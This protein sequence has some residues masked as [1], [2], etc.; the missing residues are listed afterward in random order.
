MRPVAFLSMLLLAGLSSA[1]VKNGAGEPNTIIR[2]S[3]REVLLE[4]SVRDARGRMVTKLDPSQV[5]VYE[6]GVRQTLRSFRLVTGREVHGQEDKPS[7]K[8]A[9]QAPGEAV[10]NGGSPLNPL[11]TVN[12]ICLVLNDLDADTRA[13][14]FDAASK[15]V[16]NEL[17]PE[18]FIGVFSLDATGLRPM[19]P[20]S[21]NREHL[22]EAVRRASLNQLPVLA[23]SNAALLNGLGIAATGAPVLGEADG[24]TDGAN[25][26]DPLGTRGDMG[27]AVN[28]GLREIDALK[29]LVK[30]LSPL[31]F[32]KTVLLMGGGLTR[33]PDQID[34]WQSLI[35]SA[36]QA[37]VT[38][39]GVDVYG[40]GVCQD[41]SDC[42]TSSSAMTPSIGMLKKAATLS[43]GQ[44]S[45]GLPAASSH[46][47]GV[48][49]GGSTEGPSIAGQMMESMHQSDFVQ[50]GVLSANKQ[51]A[52]R[53]ISEST[54]GFIIANTNNTEKLLA[55]VMEDVDTHYELAYQPT[56]AINNGHFRKIEV[57]LT[58][59][60]LRVQT[61]SGYFAVPQTGDG[62]LAAAEMA[63]L[64]ALDTKPLP[65]A[66]DFESKA[67]RFR[68]ENATS[69]YSIAFQVPI[70]K[71]TATP[72]AA[73][74]KH[75]FHASLLAV[76]KDSRGEI[77]ERVSRDVPSEVSDQYLD[78]LLPQNITYEHAVDLPP[79]SYTIETAVVDQEGNRASTNVM[80][81]ENLAQKG[82]GLSDIALVHRVEELNRPPDASDPFEIPG[83]RALPFV[84]NNL[85][86]G[87]NPY[88]YFIVYPDQANPA[89]P[90]LRVQFLM[91]GKVLATQQSSL[92]QQDESGAIPM[93][94]AALAKPGD[95]E[96][97]LSVSQGKDSVER[98]LKYTIAAK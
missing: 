23:Q 9:A 94:I 7:E 79:G 37:G 18:T 1:Q 42:T 3:V 24:F 25:A 66:F 35:H 50:F 46:P 97:R 28:A 75:R 20:F 21:N 67:Y 74:K 13:F 5:T 4:V 72:E 27:L 48:V 33:P 8:T 14:A 65:H 31:P 71:L 45:S 17:R 19:F 6:D 30:Q 52:L 15:F 95:Y 34:Y 85:P 53:E 92:P 87:S 62:P 11:R 69:Q 12:A 56:S 44:A 38:F 60:D 49:L 90:G 10:Y 96:V 86:A 29:A 83:K 40:L 91:D 57:K 22:L 39:Y 98:S 81:I 16:K 63:G 64:R 88:A 68:P 78:S 58:R 84:S 41:M 59:S 36:T 43:Q 54:G 51:E 89:I 61:R 93:A 26:R 70:A 82:P 80:R 55:R 77:V 73:E 32:Q 47:G 76:V 2:S